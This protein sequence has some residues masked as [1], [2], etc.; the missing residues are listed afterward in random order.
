MAHL[1]TVQTDFA[2]ANL[3]NHQSTTT[4]HEIGDRATGVDHHITTDK[5]VALNVHEKTNILIDLAILADSKSTTKMHAQ[6]IGSVRESL[7]KTLTLAQLQH[8]T[9]DMMMTIDNHTRGQEQEVV[10]PIEVHDMTSELV[11]GILVVEATVMDTGTVV[12]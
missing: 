9:F 2:I 4:N 7:T 5:V 11:E 3:P 6:S 10:Y 1:L 12:E 8:P